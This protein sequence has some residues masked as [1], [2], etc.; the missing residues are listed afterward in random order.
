MSRQRRRLCI[1]GVGLTVMLLTGCGSTS[2]EQQ[3]GTTGDAPVQ[4]EPGAVLSGP[5]S[6]VQEGTNGSAGGGELSI[7][8]TDDGAG[9]SLANFALEN[10][11][12]SGQGVTITSEGWSKKTSFNQP[13]SIADGAFTLS[14][15]GADG[16]TEVKGQF[17][18]PTQADA[19]IV[20]S[21]TERLPDGRTLECDFGTWSW[22]GVTE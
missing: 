13:S 8:I 17:T 5:L 15:G 1:I 10:T 20:I 9:I 11:A 21:T 6:L 4:P 7:T 18:S 22:T 2:T 12:C 19:T 14:L 3:Q 16:A